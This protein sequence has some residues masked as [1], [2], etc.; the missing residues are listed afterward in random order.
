MKPVLIQGVRGGRKRGEG[1][2]GKKK[3]KEKKRRRDYFG[4]GRKGLRYPL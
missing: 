1:P 3:R 4:E 2:D